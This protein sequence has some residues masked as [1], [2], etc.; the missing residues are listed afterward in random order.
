ME[1]ALAASYVNEGYQ[2]Y[3]RIVAKEVGAAGVT[4]KAD[5]YK[6]LRDTKGHKLQEA[7]QGLTQ[8]RDVALFRELASDYNRHSSPQALALK[9]R[10]R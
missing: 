5:F 4:D 6:W 9:S 3:E 8:R 10:M 2:M 7:I 1:P